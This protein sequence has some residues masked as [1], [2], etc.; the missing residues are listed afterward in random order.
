[1]SL[2]ND[3]LKR[4]RSAAPVH[5]P[6]L[7]FR[8]VEPHQGSAGDTGLLR[9]AV[10]AIA[11]ALAVIGS[12]FLFRPEPAEIRATIPS[13][14]AP[15]ADT[16]PA[17]ASLVLSAPATPPAGPIKPAASEPNPPVTQA[18]GATITPTPSTN[19]LPP[20]GDG[21][22]PSLSTETTPPSVLVSEPPTAPSLPRLQ[23]IVSHPTR[24]S[25]IIGGKSV[26]VGDKVGT[27]R[28]VSIQPEAVTLAGGGQTN[29]LTLP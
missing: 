11:V 14:A 7:P 16:A 3:A 25:A 17:A 8:P 5:T 22:K 4:A 26:F 2:I 13:P 6:A 18:S 9:P 24:P 28:V 21:A 23:A 27:L 29:V 15:S 12:Y 20:T 1:M 10:L 19:E